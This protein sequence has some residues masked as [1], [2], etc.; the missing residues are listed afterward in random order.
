MAA[1]I[2]RYVLEIRYFEKEKFYHMIPNSAEYNMVAEFG[3]NGSAETGTQYYEVI[4]GSRATIDEQSFN[5]LI[6]CDLIYVPFPVY[7]PFVINLNH[8]DWVG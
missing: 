3:V 1:N 6:T 8:G 4:A 7:I 5:Q 2:R